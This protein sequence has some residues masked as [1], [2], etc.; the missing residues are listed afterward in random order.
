MVEQIKKGKAD[1]SWPVARRCLAILLR[2]QQGT[3]K[4]H[5]LLTT[6]YQME[7]EEAYGRTTGTALDK[8]FRSDL[9]RLET[10]FQIKVRYSKIERGYVIDWRERPLLNLPDP[11]I[12]T[13]AF[14][15]DT[16]QPDSPHAL[17]VQQLIDRLVDWLPA[18][19]QQ[20]FHK[21]A[22]HQPIA[23]LRL[24]D[25]E[26]IAPDVWDA[27]QA[28][29][30]AKQE[31][32]FDYLSTRN[33]TG[34]P[35]QHHIQP[36]DLYFTDR[37]HWRL[38]G[39]CLFS[40]G[41]DGPWQPNDYVNYRVSRIQAGSV[42]QLSRKLPAIRPHGRPRDVI[43]ELSPTIARFGVSQQKELIG[44]PKVTVL[45]GGWVCVT[46]KTYDVFELARNLL[47]Y[48]ANCR[49]LGG[50]EL[51]EEMKGLVEGLVEIYQ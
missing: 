46:S 31:V 48:G 34:I 7:G 45:D 9:S 24:R 2:L 50:K 27:I 29:W 8:R 15:A 37:R 42:R 12:Q 4:K 30:Q 17:E 43:F 11:E 38:R 10:H 32:Q 6:V 16:F 36:W 26:P 13:L 35:R 25:S 39:Y 23:D 20:L 22:G 1:S 18:E 19:R 47:Y 44:E 40:D 51:L 5:E 3:A 14:L 28:V 41:P 21:A 49:V 33:E